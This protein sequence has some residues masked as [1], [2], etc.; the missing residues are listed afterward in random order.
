MW[1]FEK[2]ISESAPRI[3]TELQLIEFQL[4]LSKAGIRV[5]INICL[6]CWA[7]KAAF[8]TLLGSR[9]IHIKQNW[10]KEMIT[11]PVQEP[12]V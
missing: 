12:S 1:G 9:P 5:F 8:Y 11:A 3:S 10:H 6:Q 4:Y 2:S 7:L